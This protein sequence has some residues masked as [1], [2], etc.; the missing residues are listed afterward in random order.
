MDSD[1]SYRDPSRHRTKLFQALNGL[2]SPEFGQL[3]YGL[4]PP[5][6][7][8]PDSDAPQMKRVKA[9][10]DW[11]EGSTG[12]GT[13]EI[14]DSLAQ[15]QQGSL[16]FKRQAFPSFQPYL[17]S[18]TAQ[19]GKWWEHYTLT[20]VEGKVKPPKPEQPSVFDFGL[21]VQTVAKEKDSSAPDHDSRSEHREKIERL[22]VLEGIRKYADGHV[23][24]VGR[25]G[26]G[27]STALIRLLLEEAS[28]F[29]AKPPDA[30]TPSPS[31]KVGRGEQEKI[32]VL[33]ELRYWQGSIEGLIQG[34][35]KRHGLMLDDAALSAQLDEGRFLLLVD[36]LNELPTEE[37]RAQL[38]V[39]RRSYPHIPMIFTT[40]DL[41][42]GGDLGIEKKLEM[43]PL[44]EAQMKAFIRAYVPNQAEAMLRQLNHR[45]RDFGQTPLLLWM[46][47]EVFQQSPNQQLPNNLAEVF[48]AFTTMY[49][50]SSVRK[51]EVALLKGDVRP[52]SD[53]RLWKPALMA[54]AALMMQGET[55]VDFR[56]AIHRTEAERELGKIFA[57][58]KFPVR[59]ILDDLLKYHLLQK[60]TTG[61]LE[62]RHQL[63]Q[64]YYAAEHLLCLLPE[65]S[66]DQIKRDYLNL[67]KW[68]EPIALMLALVDEDQNALGIVSRAI[69]EIDFFLGS[70]LAG[71]VK[72]HLQDIS[73]NYID[74]LIV[75]SE[76]KCQIWG[77]SQSE[78]AVPKLIKTFAQPNNY[79]LNL[80][81][82]QILCRDPFA[83]SLIKSNFLEN[84]SSPDPK[85]RGLAC[86]ILGNIKASSA[87]PNLLHS[88]CF[89]NDSVRKKA[90]KALGEIGDEA[91]IPELLKTL[92]EADSEIRCLAVEALGGIGNDKVIPLLIEAFQD[93]SYS[94]RVKASEAI[95]KINSEPSSVAL[96]ESIKSSK[97]FVRHFSKE[98][99]IKM[100][101]DS[102]ISSL[103]DMMSDPLADNRVT[104]I[105][106]L[107]NLVDENSSIDLLPFLCDSEEFVRM[108][109]ISSL[110]KTGNKL[111]IPCLI[112]ALSD[113]S[114]YVRRS[115]IESLGKLGSEA[116]LHHVMRF[117]NDPD[118]HTRISVI[119]ALEAIGDKSCAYELLKF[120]NDTSK[121]VRIRAIKSLR[122]FKI[123]SRLDK[124]SLIDA[125]TNTLY[126]LDE[127][128]REVAIK[129]LGEIGTKFGVSIPLNLLL[130]A[131]K[132]KSAGVRQNAEKVL[133][134]N[135]SN[136]I[137]PDL[138]IS[139]QDSDYSVR[140]AA[141]RI[142]GKLGIKELKP[143]LFHSLEEPDFIISLSAAFAL[144]DIQEVSVL[145]NLWFLYCQGKH[146]SFRKAITQIQGDCKFYNYE[147]W[148]ET[149]NAQKTAKEPSEAK[150]SPVSNIFPNATKVKIIERVEHYYEKP[151][152]SGQ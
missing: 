74:K 83:S 56:V 106:I 26:S 22:P 45:L 141:I 99:L 121:H 77:E 92:Q 105:S 136:A 110:G 43:Q 58:E 96:L 57:K 113:H 120:L 12:R 9:L 81:A 29:T 54:L 145:P 39:F 42:L 137:L 30:L 111:M 40:R 41:G 67:L 143:Y 75:P 51:H 140:T 25:P 78:M 32:P 21:M 87:V 52:L 139:L 150:A 149:I 123:S 82:S 84:L 101:N 85:I 88:L 114:A 13:D 151:P 14:W 108:Y 119:T 18:I 122:N 73:I 148:Q 102:I 55:L 97:K 2:T 144:A 4:Q 50:D 65:L 128:V 62:F 35:L 5:A 63:I 80:H 72:H 19:Y 17:Q 133:I 124:S 126:D 69:N 131:L 6:G 53:R 135:G 89:D 3:L 76:I 127:K 11:A 98:A 112:D 61:Q 142:S 64:E 23:L 152:N 115:A 109:A 86:E 107:D 48:R 116:T 49:E 95:A 10:L 94:V 100:K 20:D 60:R 24:L 93:S 36:G 47:C 90:I 125:L 16:S 27:K 117:C 59:D 34:F 46:L 79:A 146:P 130:E 33:V 70:R 68:T 147:I 8:I 132:E 104:A 44:T 15:L 37:A 134:E 31:P 7:L 91:A 71:A 129:A 28:S 38:S 118:E 1:S 138:L 103:S 66:D